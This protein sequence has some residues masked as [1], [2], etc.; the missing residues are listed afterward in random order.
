MARL[1]RAIHACPVPVVSAVGHEIDFS[2]A[3]FVADLRAPTPSAAAE[4]LVPDAVAL[5]R[6]LDQLQRR[7]VALQERRLQARVQRIDHLLARL[8]SAMRVR[9]LHD[10]VLRRIELFASHDGKL[11]MVPVGDALDD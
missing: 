4:L 6:H 3:D 11:P 10:T 9:A 8:Q 1:A 5:R 2:I 7:I